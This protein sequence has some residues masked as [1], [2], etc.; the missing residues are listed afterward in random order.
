[1]GDLITPDMMRTAM[2]ARI[3]MG[4]DQH[5]ISLLICLF[6]NPVPSERKPRTD[7]KV[8]RFPVERIPEGNRAAFLAALET[9]RP[10]AVTIDWLPGVPSRRAAGAMFASSP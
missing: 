3:A 10:T 1:M 7:G 9:E 2:R 5:S 4:V 8:P 6:V